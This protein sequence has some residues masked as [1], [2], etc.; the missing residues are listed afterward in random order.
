[1]PRNFPGFF[2]FLPLLFHIY[3]TELFQVF[4]ACLG[5]Y[6]GFTAH[7][8][9]NFFPV[10]LFSLCDVSSTCLGTL[11]FMLNAF[12]LF[13]VSP[14]SLGTLRGTLLRKWEFHYFL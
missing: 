7:L 13:P 14:M 12:E 11:R 10:S 2:S 5:T 9:W 1:M 6:P 4:L 8:Y 3:D